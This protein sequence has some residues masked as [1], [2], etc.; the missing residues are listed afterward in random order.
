[1]LSIAKTKLIN[2]LKMGKFR[3]EHGLFIAEG[4]TNVLDLIN[5]G[6]VVSDLFATTTWIETNQS[7]IPDQEIVQVSDK[8]I[9]KLSLLKTPSA[10]VGVFEIPVHDKIEASKINDLVLMLDNIR[11]PGN[12][13]TIIRTADWFGI[14][15]IICSKESVDAFNPKVVQA[16]MGSISRVKIHYRNLKNFLESKPEYLKVFGTVLNGDNLIEIPKPQHGIILIGNEA[17]GISNELLPLVNQ[18][19]TIPLIANDSNGSAESLN[20][21]IATA[22]I[23]YEFRR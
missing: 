14:K 17:H 7:K 5:N 22:I 23:C 4:T 15:D 21:S 16:S 12:L 6:T 11:D 1:M 13:G 18:K 2:S 19:V 10:I 8:E 3:K 9:K 20:A